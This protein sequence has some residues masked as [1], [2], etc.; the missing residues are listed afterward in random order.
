MFTIPENIQWPNYKF[1]R[2]ADHDIFNMPYSVV[3]WSQNPLQS[4]FLTPKMNHPNIYI[5]VMTVP[6]LAT[7]RSNVTIP[8]Q[9][10]P[11]VLCVGCLPASP[12]GSRSPLPPRPASH[13]GRKN[14]QCQD[15]TSHSPTTSQIFFT[16]SIE[17][18]ISKSPVP[19]V[20][21]FRSTYSCLSVCMALGSVYISW[22]KPFS[23]HVTWNFEIVPQVNKRNNIYYYIFVQFCNLILN[24]L[25]CF[26][27]KRKFC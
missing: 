8:R 5:R 16:L 14:T 7:N 18:P 21:C 9:V 26:L 27:I 3:I 12:L 13:Q 4:I 19:G 11:S 1:F 6:S 17:T 20:T 25:I 2:V 15:G 22:D 23:D 10:R 24:V